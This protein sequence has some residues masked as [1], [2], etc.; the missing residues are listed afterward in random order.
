MMWTSTHV[1]ELIGI[2]PTRKQV[3]VPITNVYEVVDGKMRRTWIDYDSPY[4]IL[5]Q[6]QE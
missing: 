1:G 3:T 2:P 6:I 4:S 5:S